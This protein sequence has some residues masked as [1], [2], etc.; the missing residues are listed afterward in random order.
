MV[1]C[2][3]MTMVFLAFGLA[4][5]CFGRSVLYVKRMLPHTGLKHISVKCPLQD[6]LMVFLHRISLN[7]WTLA[8]SGC[9]HFNAYDHLLAL[10]ECIPCGSL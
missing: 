2:G 6:W 3:V 9:R 1:L 7:R 5:G 4:L 8:R 10:L